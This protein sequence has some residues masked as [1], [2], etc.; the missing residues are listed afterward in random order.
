MSHLADIAKIE[1]NI[2]N[3]DCNGLI[4][5]RFKITNVSYLTVIDRINNDN[6]L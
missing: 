1:V 4:G 2:F 3:K 6:Q 5:N